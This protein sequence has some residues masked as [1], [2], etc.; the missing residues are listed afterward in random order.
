MHSYSIVTGQLCATKTCILDNTE[1][2]TEPFPDC[3]SVAEKCRKG[4][5]TREDFTPIL[6]LQ[7]TSTSYIVFV[8]SE[9]HRL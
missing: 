7:P 4:N 9:G 3:Q 1:L 2:A 5:D 6:H 8:S